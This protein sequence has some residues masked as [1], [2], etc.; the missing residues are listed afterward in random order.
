MPEK[1]TFDYDITTLRGKVIE[2][3]AT[4]S[5]GNQPVPVYEC[6]FGLRTKQRIQVEPDGSL[7]SIVFFRDGST[8]QYDVLGDRTKYNIGHSRR[9]FMDGFRPRFEVVRPA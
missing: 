1:P 5:A 6:N 4:I 2:H 7:S 9:F 8:G 3:R